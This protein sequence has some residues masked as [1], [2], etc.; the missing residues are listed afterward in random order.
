MATLFARQRLMNDSKARPLLSDQYGTRKS[1]SLPEP[2]QISLEIVSR[3]R[4]VITWRLCLPSSFQL[5]GRGD[6][7]VKPLLFLG[8][9]G[10]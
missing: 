4:G 2:S 8:S 3:I 9:F 7:R 10:L 6:T 5:F 1:L